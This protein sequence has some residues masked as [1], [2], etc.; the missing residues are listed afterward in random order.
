MRRN[1]RAVRDLHSSADVWRRRHD[2]P[3]RVYAERLVPERF[4]LRNGAQRVWWEHLVRTEL[5]DSQHVRR[6]RHEQRLRVQVAPGDVLELLWQR[7]GQL[8]PRVQRQHLLRRRWR[9]LPRGDAGPHGRRHRAR[10]RDAPRR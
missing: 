1:G 7:H 4:E 9:V 3:V 2:P 6:W 8:R 5:H 10:D